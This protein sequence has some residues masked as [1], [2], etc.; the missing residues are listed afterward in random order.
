[1]P[2]PRRKQQEQPCDTNNNS[3]HHERRTREENR[4]DGIM[5]HHGPSSTLFFAFSP[6][7]RWR[8]LIPLRCLFARSAVFLSFPSTATEDTVKREDDGILYHGPP[9]SEFS[10]SIPLPLLIDFWFFLFPHWYSTGNGGQ[11]KAMKTM[12]SCSMD[13]RRLHRLPSPPNHGGRRSRFGAF[14]ICVFFSFS[15]VIRR[16][17]PPSHPFRHSEK[18]EESTMVPMIHDDI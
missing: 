3:I 4:V 14:S 12:E 6:Q 16:F 18:N 13:L 1:M 7:S 17:C 11:G 10:R 9:L 15:P 2:R 8:S 5:Y